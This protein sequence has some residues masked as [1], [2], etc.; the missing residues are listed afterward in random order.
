MNEAAPIAREEMPCDVAIIGA[1]P[2]GLSAAIRLAQLAKEAGR[3][4]SICVVEKGAEVGAHILSGAVFEPRA[5]DELLPDWKERGA[6]LTVPAT[7]DR[8][9][10]LTK[11]KAYRLPT[12]PGMHNRGNYV[13]SIANLCRWL[14]DVAEGMGVQIFPGFPAADLFMENGRVAGIVTGDFGIGKDGHRKPEFQPGLILRAKYTLF[15]EG[16]RGS[17]SQRLMEQFNLRK[18]CDPQTYALGL[19]EIWEVAPEKHKPGQ[20]VHS[21][22]WPLK[23]DTYGGSFLYHMDANQIAIGYVV[24]LDYS[25]PYLDPFQEFQRFK[26][27][28]AIRPLLEGGRRLAYGAR[29]LNEGGWQSLPKLAFPGGVLIGCAAGF[30]NVAKIK[31]NHLAMKSGML[32]AESAFAALQENR[33]MDVLESYPQAVRDSWIAPE[34]Q[35]VRNIRP[36]FHLG[37]WAGMLNGAL[38]TLLRGRTP[39]TLRNHADH[40][41]LNPASLSPR[42]DYPR[43]DGVVSFDRLSSVYLSNTNHAEDQP[44]HLKLRDPDLAIEVNLPDYASPETRYCPAGVYEIVEETSGPRLQINAQN[45]VHC[46]TCDLKDPNL[47]IVWTTP[48]GGGGPR[49]PNM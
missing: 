39:W 31:G 22:G 10:F 21:I 43:P 29:A 8:F 1:G 47:N 12:P 23:N 45:C 19:K 38:E 11:K 14:A 16:C 41:Q 6:P 36:G 7:N 4:I 30:L 37:L 40:T 2:A 5:L 34:L 32:A 33:A 15:A 18:D 44:V 24:G 17:L 3:E 13:T 20:V 26:Q 9:L 27:H 49:Y 25:N 35:S 28:P 46:K 48:E 42:I